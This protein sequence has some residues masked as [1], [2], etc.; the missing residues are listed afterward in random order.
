MEAT[1]GF[2]IN[3]ETDLNL[4]AIL[5]RFG[6]HKLP[7]IG[8]QIDSKLGLDTTSFLEP[9]LNTL[10]G[11]GVEVSYPKMTFLVGG[12]EGTK[13]GSNNVTRLSSPISWGRRIIYQALR[14][15]EHAVVMASD[16]HSASQSCRHATQVLL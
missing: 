4:G 14:A 8:F 2:N 12:Y 16:H 13:G 1:I 11:A 10:E 6:Y 7:E 15:T 5:E 9:F 3:L